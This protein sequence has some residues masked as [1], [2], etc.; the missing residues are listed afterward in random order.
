MGGVPIILFSLG[1]LF[2]LAVLSYNTIRK[3]YWE[4]SATKKQ[5]KEALVSAL[6]QLRGSIDIKDSEEKAVIEKEIIE[7]QSLIDRDSYKIV[8]YAIPRIQQTLKNTTIDTAALKM[9]LKKHL[10]AQRSYNSF[11]EQMPSKVVA[12]LAGYKKV[13]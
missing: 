9:M 1:F 4:Y 11:V 6:E 3:A 5:L 7:Q 10:H 2:L 8:V 13:G 12:N